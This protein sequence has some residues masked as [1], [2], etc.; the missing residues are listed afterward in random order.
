MQIPTISKTITKIAASII[1]F[2]RMESEALELDPLDSLIHDAESKLS[3]IC[4]RM[5]MIQEEWGNLTL[6]K[7]DYVRHIHYLKLSMQT[8][9]HTVMRIKKK[10]RY[11]SL[12]VVSD[13][14]YQ[15]TQIS[16]NTTSS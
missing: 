11:E 10:R 12:T 15:P 2:F 13:D 9:P 16:T 6:M 1:F 14:E 5:R 8:V 4:E 7:N 3:D